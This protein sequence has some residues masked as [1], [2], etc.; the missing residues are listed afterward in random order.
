MDMK[1]KAEDSVVVYEKHTDPK[2][3]VVPLKIIKAK[4]VSYQ[5]LDHYWYNDC[6]YKAWVNPQY[7]P[8]AV[9]IFLDMKAV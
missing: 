4:P 5:G 9:L 3:N 1:Y 7:A 8:D 2:A 6:L